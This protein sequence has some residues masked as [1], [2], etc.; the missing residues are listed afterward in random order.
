MESTAAVTTH[1]ANALA[2]RLTGSVA[3]SAPGEM[4]TATPRSSV[5]SS[6]SLS[7]MARVRR[8]PDASETNTDGTP[9]SASVGAFAIGVNAPARSS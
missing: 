1:A 9:T 3:F 7:S 6:G 5:S 8:F 2:A 4:R